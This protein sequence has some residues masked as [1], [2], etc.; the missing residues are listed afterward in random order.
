MLCILFVF[1]TF[2]NSVWNYF[3]VQLKQESGQTTINIILLFW[4]TRSVWFKHFQWLQG[5]VKSESQNEL[6]TFGSTTIIVIDKDKKR[7]ELI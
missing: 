6:K 4:D 3:F 1:Y 5:V 7:D 2:L